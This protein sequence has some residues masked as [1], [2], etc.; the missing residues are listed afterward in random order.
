MFI[1][2]IIV[3]VIIAVVTAVIANKFTNKV[4]STIMKST[5]LGNKLNENFNLMNAKALKKLEE[6]LQNGEITQEQYE[7]RKK[8]LLQDIDFN[9]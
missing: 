2:I 6:K 7:K 4:H 8:N 1:V 3:I 5:G 9:K